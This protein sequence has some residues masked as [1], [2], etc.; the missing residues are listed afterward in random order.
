MHK[1][2]ASLSYLDNSIFRLENPFYSAL[3]RPLVLSIPVDHWVGIL[4]HLTATLEK[5]RGGGT[6]DWSTMDDEALGC[7]VDAWLTALR[8]QG[9]SER[10]ARELA[11]LLGQAMSAEGPRD[12]AESRVLQ[13]FEA[14]RE[15]E[16]PQKPSA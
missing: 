11:G 12:T 6:M 3:P 2:A 10:R 14:W 13:R 4:Y 5:N 9:L 15:S 1:I 7:A 8:A 16:L